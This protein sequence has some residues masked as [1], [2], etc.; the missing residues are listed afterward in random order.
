M[1]S[2]KFT[3]TGS[4]GAKQAESR[5][6]RT[7]INTKLTKDFLKR[8]KEKPA[9]HHQNNNV[10]GR[11]PNGG[12]QQNK[13]LDSSSRAGITDKPNVKREYSEVKSASPTTVISLPKIQ[14]RVL[15]LNN[16]TSITGKPRRGKHDT[17]P[18][19]PKTERRSE[20][21]G[22]LK[23]AATQPISG[24]KDCHDTKQEPKVE[25]RRPAIHSKAVR[26][27]CT[28]GIPMLCNGQMKC[29]VEGC[30]MAAYQRG[31]C[32]PH[33]GRDKCRVQDCKNYAYA[34]ELCQTHQN[35]ISKNTEL[36]AAKRDPKVSEG[37]SNS[38]SEPS[39]S[40]VDAVK[41]NASAVQVTMKKRP[42]LQTTKKRSKSCKGDAW[43][44]SDLPN[45]FRNAG[46]KRA[47]ETEDCV[48]SVKREKVEIDTLGVVEVKT[49]AKANTNKSPAVRVA[50][51]RPTKTEVVVCKVRGCKLPVLSDEFCQKHE[52]RQRCKED[53]CANVAG[54]KSARGFCW[55][56]AGKQCLEDGCTTKARVRGRCCKHGGKY[57]CREKGCKKTAYLRGLCGAHV[58]AT[59]SK[60]S[61]KAAAPQRGGH[62]RAPTKKGCKK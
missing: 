29:K 7:R 12:Q 3:K 39:I 33:G 60:T 13:K 36:E 62:R 14:R 17:S 40:N 19:P 10:A 49:S 45:L 8:S 46:R 11:P 20:V 1:K 61:G 55:H 26:A 38:K 51:S 42:N 43:N 52:K 28:N 37:D 21:V 31:L 27:A 44:S 48:V 57:Y 2:S 24:D 18:L 50:R 41:T 54:K 25:E 58:R 32:P 5:R 16:E 59:E 22:G 6:C 34:Q 53:G 30:Y 15:D 9:T 35:S 56:H 4:S 23:N 47:R